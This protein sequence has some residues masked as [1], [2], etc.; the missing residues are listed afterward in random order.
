MLPCQRQT[1]N[2]QSMWVQPFLL[3]SKFWCGK[4]LVSEVIAA[5]LMCKNS[6]YYW[7]NNNNLTSIGTKQCSETV[8]SPNPKKEEAGKGTAC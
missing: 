5:T 2:E 8:V 4:H 6:K 7:K 1:G 3:C